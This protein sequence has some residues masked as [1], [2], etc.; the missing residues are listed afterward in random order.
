MDRLVKTHLDRTND[1]GF[2]VES[3]QELVRSVGAAQV[4]EYQCVDIFALEA[5]EWI[6]F[7]AQLLVECV[8]DLHLAVDGKVG[9]SFLHLCH[10][11]VNLDR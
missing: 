10:S 2:W 6:F 1:L 3:L 11:L 4:R 7:I 5:R 9:V 8:V